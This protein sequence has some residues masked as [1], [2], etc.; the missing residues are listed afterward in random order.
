MDRGGGRK[1]TKK[2]SGKESGEAKLAVRTEGEEMHKEV[3]SF[4][5]PPVRSVCQYPPSTN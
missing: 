3:H 1:N 2:K 5:M 4:I